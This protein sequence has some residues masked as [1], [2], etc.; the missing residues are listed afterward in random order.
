MGVGKE[1]DTLRPGPGVHCG[2]APPASWVMAGQGGWPPG[3]G[4]LALPTP[5]RPRQLVP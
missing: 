2:S 3:S 4:A 5:L 1:E